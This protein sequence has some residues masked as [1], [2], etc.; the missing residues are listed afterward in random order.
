MFPLLYHF[1]SNCICLFSVLK[2]PS[3]LARGRRDNVRVL[4]Q[5]IKCLF[6]F[7]FFFFFWNM[8]MH[9]KPKIYNPFQKSLHRILAYHSFLS[10]ICR[11]ILQTPT[12]V[13]D[14]SP[15]YNFEHPVYEAE[16]SGDEE[17][18]EEISRL[19]KQ[20][21]RVIQPF[22]EPLEVVN[23][24]SEEEVKEIRIGALLDDKIK[25]RL[26]ELLKEYVD[27]FAWSYQ[28]MPGLD[29][30]IVEHRLPLKPE[31]PPVKQKLRRTHPDMAQKIKEEVQK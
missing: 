29:T 31:C 2:N 27:V 23:L 15:P 17:I 6:V 3:T 4:L 30:D 28:D 20:E 10:P 26:I 11:L 7:L 21:D 1:Q 8:V 18:P 16:E 25:P 14:P 24:G 22:Q 12:K 19:L 13:N 5:E 9:K